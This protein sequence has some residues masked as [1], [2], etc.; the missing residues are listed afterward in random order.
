M[1]GFNASGLE[2]QFGTM[3]AYGHGAVNFGGTVCHKA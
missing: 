2:L 1:Y 3:L